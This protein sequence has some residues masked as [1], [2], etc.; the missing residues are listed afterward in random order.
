MGSDG[1]FFGKMFW[2][3]FSPSKPLGHIIIGL[4]GYGLE[5]GL[6]F[7]VKFLQSLIFQAVER[8]SQMNYGSRSD[9]LAKIVDVEACEY[10]Y[11]I[12]L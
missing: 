8:R 12:V 5:M 2:S 10:L 6:G 7:R 11:R 3:A 4:V 9:G 1:R